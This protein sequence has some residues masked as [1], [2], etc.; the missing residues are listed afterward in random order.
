MKASRLLTDED[1]EDDLIDELSMADASELIH[2]GVKRIQFLKTETTDQAANKF[3]DYQSNIFSLMTATKT[4][5]NNLALVELLDNAIFNAEQGFISEAYDSISEKIEKLESELNRK[6]TKESRATEITK[7]L[8][9]LNRFKEA[10]AFAYQMPSDIF[11]NVLGKEEQGEIEVDEYS[12]EIKVGDTV[13]SKQNNN[14]TEY[15]VK[16]ITSKNIILKDTKGK[17][18]S[19]EIGKFDEQYIT[20]S[21]MNAGEFTPPEYNPT[22]GEKSIIQESQIVVEDFLRNS[23]EDKYKAYQDGINNTPAQ[24]RTNLEKI[25]KSCP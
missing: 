12:N 18:I 16:S 17:E 4:N 6:Y 9:N 5:A 8:S 25:I 10:L 20:E 14:N 13:Y 11:E 15:K 19:V 3:K 22:E 21:E 1:I 23:T 7:E 24:N 2:E